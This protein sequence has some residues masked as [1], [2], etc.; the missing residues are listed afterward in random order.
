M[1]SGPIIKQ[2]SHYVH[3]FYSIIWMDPASIKHCCVGYV[4]VGTPK[5]SD[6]SCISCMIY[7]SYAD[8]WSRCALSFWNFDE[9]QI[10]NYR[11]TSGPT[12]ENVLSRD[13]GESSEW[14]CNQTD[15][16]GRDII[17]A[18]NRLYIWQKVQVWCL[19]LWN[20]AKSKCTIITLKIIFQKC[21]NLT[22]GLDVL[23]AFDT[24][25][26]NQFKCTTILLLY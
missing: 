1:I 4:I 25:K 18:V 8:Y 22:R 26:R 3:I 16:F 10:R 9:Q 14:P 24:V 7:W 11:I 21:V 6:Q 13:G 5:V 19:M 20:T 12:V 23:K 2:K 17:I 15:R